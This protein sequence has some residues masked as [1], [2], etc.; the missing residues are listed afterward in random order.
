MKSNRCM[1]RTFAHI[2][3]NAQKHV[4]LNIVWQQPS[5]KGPHTCG[6]AGSRLSQHDEQHIMDMKPIVLQAHGK[7]QRVQSLQRSRKKI[8]MNT[9]IP[10]KEVQCGNRMETIHGARTNTHKHAHTPTHKTY[11]HT[12]HTQKEWHID[13]I[14]RLGKPTQTH[15]QEWTLLTL[16]SWCGRSSSGCSCMGRSPSEGEEEATQR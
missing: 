16:C 3:V 2:C 6:T 10:I 4:G 11:T 7:R 14:N 13:N 12:P 9:S 1:L 15:T 5:L 8:Q